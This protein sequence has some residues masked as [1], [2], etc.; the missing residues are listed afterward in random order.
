MQIS[1]CR[2][3]LKPHK[4]QDSFTREKRILRMYLLFLF[5][6]CFYLD[7]GVHMTFSKN[8]SGHR[9]LSIAI[10]SVLVLFNHSVVWGSLAQAAN[11]YDADSNCFWQLESALLDSNFF[12]N[13]RP[14][15]TPIL[16]AWI[17]QQLKCLKRLYS[18]F[19]TSDYISAKDL[20]IMDIKTSSFYQEIIFTKNSFS[21]YFIIY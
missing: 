2:F 16:L 19:L 13:V 20:F 9:F 17:T 4:S 5:I 21:F 11:S 7:R 14:K 18:Y 3:K 10:T 12:Q 8:V 6:F 1:R 15:R